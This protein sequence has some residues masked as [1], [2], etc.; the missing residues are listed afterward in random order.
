MKG[1]GGEEEQQDFFFPLSF[2]PLLPFGNDPPLSTFFLL[3]QD[4]GHG[5]GD[6]IA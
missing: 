5:G 6:Y 3:F 4:R 2:S 1:A